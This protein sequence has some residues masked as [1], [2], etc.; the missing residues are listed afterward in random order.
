MG[1]FLK[2]DDKLNSVAKS[3]GTT[4]DTSGGGSGFDNVVVPKEKVHL[5][6]ILWID[7]NIG[8]GIIISQNFENRNI[9][10][11]EWNFINLAWLSK[12]VSSPNGQSFWRKDLLLKVPLKNIE[13][14][15]DQLIKTSLE[16]LSAIKE[17]DLGYN[18]EK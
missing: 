11:P 13:T 5:R 4:V 9:D 14:N 3:L 17:S 1:I 6:K 2:I 16:N 10:T 12:K 18:E 7:G 15:I 8:K